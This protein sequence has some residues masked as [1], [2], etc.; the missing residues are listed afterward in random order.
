MTDTPLEQLKAEIGRAYVSPWLL[1][2][3]GM[4]DRFAD[5]TGDHQFIH[6]DPERAAQTPFG[7]TIAHGF[8][9]LSLLVRLQAEAGRP[10]PEGVR[11]GVNYGFDRVR[12]T[13]PV[14]SGSRVRG[15]FTLASV[16]EKRPGQ[17]QQLAE[18]VMDIEG[19]DKP[20]LTAAWIG[21]L[22]Y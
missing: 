4:I 1:V 22:F 12:F 15:R 19:S 20:A 2:D 9:L 8:L 6:V 21:Q 13:A 7:G 17:L 16:E 5:V 10:R 3:Q 11:M 18:V 14:R